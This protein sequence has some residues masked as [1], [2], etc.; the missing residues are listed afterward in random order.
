MVGDNTK[1]DVFC[2]ACGG[3]EVGTMTHRHCKCPAYEK[4]R[5]S[6]LSQKSRSKLKDGLGGHIFREH[7]ILMK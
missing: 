3:E 7:G 5:D 6:S 1:E 2:K 4:I